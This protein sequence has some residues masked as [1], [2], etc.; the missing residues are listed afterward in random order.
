MRLVK[1]VTRESLSQGQS[2]L[3]QAGA[4]AEKG[5]DPI[6]ILFHVQHFCHGV[7]P[8]ALVY[9]HLLFFASAEA[10]LL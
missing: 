3:T 1:I 8:L 5:S 7:R 9:T 6:T 2:P 4:D 10:V